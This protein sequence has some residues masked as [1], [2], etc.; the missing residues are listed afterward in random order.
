MNLNR[1]A[2]QYDAVSPWVGPPTD[3]QPCLEGDGRT[4]VAIVGGGYMGLSA[5]LRLRRAGRQVAVLEQSFCGAGASGRNAGHLTPTIGKDIYT[6]IRQW[7]AERGLALAAFAEAAVDATEARIRALNLD[8]DYVSAGNIVAGLHPRHRPPLEAAA[9]AMSAAGLPAQF[10]DAGD[11]RARGLPQA[12]RFGVLERRGGHLDPGKYAFGLRQAALAA[13]V[14]IFENTAVTGLKDGPRPRLQTSHGEVSAEQIFIAT[15]AYLQP[16]LASAAG[17][18][19][20]L[21]VTLFRT[22]RLTDAQRRGLG[23][24]GGEGIYTAHEIMESYRITRDGR[25]VGGSK[26]VELG[27][28]RF[29]MARPAESD[30]TRYDALVA[31]R[32]PEAAGLAIEAYWSGWIGATVD[33]LPIHGTTSRSN[34]VHYAL[35]CNG[36]GIALASYLGE[37]IA[38]RMLGLARVDLDVFR[39][40]IPDIPTAALRWAAFRAV[41]WPLERRDQ[42]IDQEIARACST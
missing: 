42:R 13:G 15:N 37:A 5:A 21:R 4:E 11:M 38:E 12:F 23:W 8:C 25:L 26:W 40:W 28:G 1:P 18:I 14:Q 33:H 7:G 2:G 22:G 10:L 16:D 31:D 29:D 35:G 30:L 19:L 39:R 27:P 9:A 24:P 20:P 3:L 17:R 32:F 41:A 36:H 34:T 6:C